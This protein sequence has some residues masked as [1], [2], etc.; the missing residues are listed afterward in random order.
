MSYTQIAARVV[1]QTL[2]LTNLPP[3]ASGGVDSIQIKFEFCPLW[4][5]YGKSAVFHRE[6]ETPIPIPIVEGMALVPHEV[7]PDAGHFFLGV[8]GAAENIRTTEVVRVEYKQGTITNAAAEHETPAPDIYQQLLA[9]YGLLEARL[10]NIIAGGTPEDSELIDL[11]V[12]LDGTV[13]NTAGDAVRGHF[14]KVAPVIVTHEIG[15]AQCNLTAEEIYDHVKAGRQVVLAWNNSWYVPL[16]EAKKSLANF[17]RS[18]FNDRGDSILVSLTVDGNGILTNT[19]NTLV[20]VEQLT[21]VIENVETRAVIDDTT[22]GADAWSSQNIVDKL[23][24]AFTESGLVVT[25]EP[26]EGYP[27][28][29]TTEEGTTAITRCGKN[30]INY[31][32]ESKKTYGVT[33]TVNEDKT[34]TVNGTST[35]KIYFVVGKANLVKGAEYRVS[36][37]PAGGNG[38]TYNLYIDNNQDTGRGKKFAA[39]STYEFSLTFYA[40]SGL[41]FD[42]VIIKPMLRQADTPSTYEPPKAVET[43][44]PGDT[45]PALP[46]INTVFA[47]AGEVSVTGRTDPNAINRKTAERLEALEAALVNT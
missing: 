42:N 20:T 7:M 6:G 11:R 15:S 9:A 37:C 14:A 43:F 28:S 26:V 5:G 27:L 46:G 19:G 30:L 35:G 31:T 44:A 16:T 2:Q 3:L 33:F 22:V 12:G 29:V 8:M 40:A 39:S 36:G 24:P 41:T 32:A 45:I 10:N 34:I 1:D 13:Y 25:C 18:T 38:A 23:C 4:D 21:E 17:D 47:N